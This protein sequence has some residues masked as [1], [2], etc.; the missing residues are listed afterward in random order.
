[1]L[2]LVRIFG[3]AVAGDKSALLQ[4]LGNFM[5]PKF[6]NYLFRNLKGPGPEVGPFGKQS[7]ALGTVE[8]QV[9]VLKRADFEAEESDAPRLAWSENPDQSIRVQLRETEGIL[10]GRV[11]IKSTVLYGISPELFASPPEKEHRHLISLK[12]VVLQI[13]SHLKKNQPESVKASGPDFDTPIAQVAREDEGFFRLEENV[14]KPD[15]AAN[16]PAA[17]A[18]TASGLTPA[19][20]PSFPLIRERARPPDAPIGKTPLKVSVGPTLPHFGAPEKPKNNL[21]QHLPKV[22]AK[23]GASESGPKSEAINSA[24]PGAAVEDAL[25]R[26]P[27]VGSEPSLAK[28]LRQSGLERLQ[29]IFLTDNL[30]DGRQVAH[31]ISG[32]PRVKAALI[33]LTDGTVMGGELPEGFSLEAAQSVPDLIRAIQQFSAR[34]NGAEIMG[35][36]MLGDLPIS[37]F[38][39]GCVNLIVVHEGRGLMPGM[40]ERIADIVLALDVLF[41][42]LEI[43][44]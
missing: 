34:L 36:T 12:T 17:T 9:I 5:P 35:L 15:P 14:V 33:L 1:L 10:E 16:A 20:R 25:A 44:Q 18:P 24:G 31:L 3:Y 30:L 11:T 8:E 23:L 7:E 27:P 21:F 41:N 2:K 13:Q 29:E 39:H 6:G 42:G 40:R 19:D 4:Q 26:K 43:K 28:P 37:L 32:L 22:G 38:S